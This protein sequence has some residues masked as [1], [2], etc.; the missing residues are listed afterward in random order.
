MYTVIIKRQPYD[1]IKEQDRKTQLHLF[2]AIELLK[3]NPRPPKAIKLAGHDDLYRVRIGD[4][5]IVYS[6]ED[7][8]L[9]VYVI[10]IAHRRD[11]YRRL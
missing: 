6:I 3:E 10:R 4:Y 11:I 5:R 8:K 9:V 7:N 1:F 2:A